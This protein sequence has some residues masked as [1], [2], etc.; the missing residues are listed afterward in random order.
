MT[1]EPEE[2][3]NMKR[4]P[5]PPDESIFA[6]GMWQHMIWVGL[7]IAVLTIAV[8]SWAISQ[9]KEHWQ[10]M[11]FTVLTVSQLFHALAIR[12]EHFSLIRIGLLSNKPLL[13]TLLATLGIQLLAIYAPI[14]NTL[15][16]TQPLSIEELTICL[17]LSSL[18]LFAVEIEKWFARKGWIYHSQY[19]FYRHS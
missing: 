14:M 17:A 5:R 3:G 6:H 11:A 13:L 18:V 2:P 8:Q 9:N 15:L 19:R 10:T 4:P 7:L 16:K 12:S 1:A